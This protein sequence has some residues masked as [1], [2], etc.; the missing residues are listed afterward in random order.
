MRISSSI[1]PVSAL[2]MPARA[3]TRFELGPGD[4][5]TER[6]AAVGAS[7]K[8]LR[9]I[10]L[11]HLHTDHVGGLA[12]VAG[13]ADVV[14]SET[15]WDQARGVAG[16]ARGYVAK[17]WPSGLVP[18]RVQLSGPPL[19]PFPATLDLVGD[20]ALRLVPLPGHTDGHIGVVASGSAGRALIAGDAAHDAAE[21]AVAAP[22]VAAWCL[23]EGV[24]LLAAHDRAAPA[25][26]SLSGP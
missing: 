4:E 18:R 22:A 21:L 15:E 2:W 7:P 24:V 25:S 14:V 11:T 5:I 12:A 1:R 17:Q 13:T 20:G 6:L 8:D 9:W 10:V 3:W 26:V 16:A 19:G 23:D